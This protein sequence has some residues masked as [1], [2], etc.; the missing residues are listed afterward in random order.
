MNPSGQSTQ[1]QQ[2]KANMDPTKGGLPFNPQSIPSLAGAPFLSSM[3]NYAAQLGG[4]NLQTDNYY[5]MVPG[6]FFSMY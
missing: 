3:S 1:N 2:L 6:V 4:G 5:S